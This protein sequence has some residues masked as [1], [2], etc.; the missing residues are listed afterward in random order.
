MGQEQLIPSTVLQDAVR[1]LQVFVYLGLAALALLQWRRRPGQ[2]AAWMCVALSVLAAFF[3][4]DY[5]VGVLDDE[6]EGS[7]LANVA[8]ALL[9]LFPYALYRFMSSFARPIPWLRVAAPPASL[10]VALPALFLPTDGGEPLWVQI[11]VFCFLVQWLVLIGVVVVRLWRAGRGQPSIAQ[12]RMRTMSAGAAALGVAAGV[13]GQLAGSS[14]AAA[15]VQ[16]LLSAAA[17]LLL[18]GFLPPYALRQFWRRR[19]RDLRSTE[20]S[21]MEADTQQ[22]VAETL[23]AESCALL[24]G[25]GARLETAAGD[26]LATSGET[27]TGNA[28]TAVRDGSAPSRVEVD[29]R[30]HRLVTFVNEFTPFFGQEEIGRLRALAAL[31]EVALERNALFEEQRHLASVVESSGDAIITNTLDGTI[32]SWN[33][34]AENLYGYTAEEAVGRSVLLLAGGGADDLPQLLTR[35]RA[36]RPVTNHETTRIRKDG[37]T[38]YVSLSVS[39]LRDRAGNIVG[40]ATS[41]RDVTESVQLRAEQKRNEEALR[42]ARSDAERANASKTEFLSRVSHE[43]RT[44]LNAIL[45]FAQ[46][47][48]LEDLTEDQRESVDQITKGGRRLVELI[49]E[50]MD[51]S[52]IESGRLRLSFEPVPVSTAIDEAVELI[53]PLADERGIRIEREAGTSRDAFVDADP[54]R[55]GQALLNLLSNAVKYNVEGGSVR[56]TVATTDADR[57]RI[58]IADTGPGIPDDKMAMLFTPFERLGAEQ[59]AVEGVG[60]GLALTRSLLQAMGGALEVTTRVGEGSTFWMDL[61]RAEGT[62]DL[63]QEHAPDEKASYVLSGTVVYIEDNVSNVV[64]VERLLARSGVSLRTAATGGDGLLLVRESRPDLV[65]LDVHLPDVQ[66][67]E[68]LASLQGDPETSSIPVVILSADATT[69]QV[70]GLLGAGAAGYLTKPIDL[71]GFFRVLDGFLPHAPVAVPTD[72]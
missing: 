49:N 61:A 53:R 2:A 62:N 72:G 7:W 11:W 51:I 21:L 16:I 24:G 14:D 59:T 26:V 17:P 35:I 22:Q 6:R 28:D 39:P 70:D 64:L 54:Q 60:L 48:D 40:A 67:D 33:K 42:N 12:L 71:P 1:L 10:A 50:L 47:L 37:Q 3:V 13:Q 43:L 5:F 15:V 20:I 66:G 57:I 52:R 8:I 19:E 25:V 23:L 31:A 38:V 44:P 56:V 55:L 27:P 18:I 45:G 29:M 4:A 46:L 68:V 69:D 9:P 58:G 32:T 30:T 36:D 41:A 63:A 34:G 65:L